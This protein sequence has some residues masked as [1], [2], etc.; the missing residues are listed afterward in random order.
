MWLCVA[1]VLVVWLC[2]AEVLNAPVAWWIASF[3]TTQEHVRN[4]C[5]CSCVIL[6]ARDGSINQWVDEL[7]RKDVC[8]FNRVVYFFIDVPLNAGI[9]VLNAT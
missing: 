8:P 9:E 4:L 1:E 2:V 5:L 7:P 6:L 3:R